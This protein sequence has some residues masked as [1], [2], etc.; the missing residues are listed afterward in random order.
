MLRANLL[1]ETD[2]RLQER[3]ALVLEELIAAEAP[4]AAT[5]LPDLPPLVEFNAPGIY[6]IR[7]PLA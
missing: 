2:V 5:R 6:V 4:G 1:A 7:L 3:A